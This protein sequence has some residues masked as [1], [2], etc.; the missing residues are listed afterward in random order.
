MNGA[1]NVSWYEHEEN[2]IDRAAAALC[3]LRRDDAGGDEAVREALSHVDRDALVWLASR[4]ISYMDEHG[5][6][7]TVRPRGLD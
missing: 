5:F 6:P 3:E 1:T 4:A 7:D 2:E